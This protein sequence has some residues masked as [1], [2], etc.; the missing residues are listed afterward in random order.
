MYLFYTQPS[1]IHTYVRTVYAN[2]TCAADTL[3]CVEGQTACAY[4]LAASTASS[5]VSSS[6]ILF[7]LLFAAYTDNTHTLYS[8]L[9]YVTVRTL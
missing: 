1:T 5:A 8:T 9:Q 3:G 6:L 7:A 2:I 4:P